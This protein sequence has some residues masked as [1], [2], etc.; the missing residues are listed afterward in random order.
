MSECYLATAKS[1]GTWLGGGSNPGTGIEGIDT[2]TITPPV[3]IIAGNEYVIYFRIL[4]NSNPG[5]NIL[6]LDNALNYAN[7]SRAS[8]IAGGSGNPDP[9]LFSQITTANLQNEGETPRYRIAHTMYV[10]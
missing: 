10:G 2:A 4:A 8:N 6:G 9:D 1:G 5:Y 7:L 3:N